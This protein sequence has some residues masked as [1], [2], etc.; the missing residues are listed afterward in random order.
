MNA[1]IQTSIVEDDAAVRRELESL[2]NA[3]PGFCCLKTYPDAEA[4]L[5]D[6][7]QHLP[8]LVL[9]DINLPGM[10]GIDCVRRLKALR[11][12]LPILMLTIHDDS[13]AMFQSLMA[14][15]NGYLIKSHSRPKLTEALRDVFAGGAPMSRSIARKVVEFFHHL[16][17]LP[18]PE[19]KAAEVQR[20][21]PR[22][23]EILASLAKGHSYKEIATDLGISGD[24]TRKHMGRIYEKLHVHSR[25]EA[26]LKYL[27]R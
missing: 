14:G 26:L 9:M 7:P 20:L 21:T 11:P 25:T 17:Q 22:E 19:G 12:T 10:S 2:I 6:L 8:D 3:V 23:Q 4:A 24:T 5:D 15:A 27:G 1:A 18:P 13:D 16:S